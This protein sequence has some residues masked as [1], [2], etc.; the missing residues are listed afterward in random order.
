[1]AKHVF[2]IASGNQEITNIN[3]IL[4]GYSDTVIADADMITFQPYV[5][6][7]FIFNTRNYHTVEPMDGQRVTFTSAIGLLPNGEIILWS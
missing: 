4:Y 3:S 1:M 5:G 2:T 7:V 6:D